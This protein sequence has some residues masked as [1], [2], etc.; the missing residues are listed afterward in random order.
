[1][2]TLLKYEIYRRWKWLILKY[3][4]FII[5]SIILINRAFST[6]FQYNVLGASFAKFALTSLVVLIVILVEGSNSLKEDLFEECG[7]LTFTIPKKGRTILASKQILLFLQLILWIIITWGFGS[8][9]FSK[10]PFPEIA[11][12][13]SQIN[14]SPMII[15]MLFAITLIFNF[16]LIFHFSLTLTK[17]LLVNKKHSGLLSFGIF[18]L[19]I[20]LIEKIYYGQFALQVKHIAIKIGVGSSINLMS[21]SPAD[22]I[23][24]FLNIILSV[25]FFT[26]TAYLLENKMNI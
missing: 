11:Q 3:S 9:F 1:M 5:I 13:K 2:I 20:Y 10:L 6:G 26:T 17:T 4:A 15:T 8:V 14:T 16:V 23:S 12:I 18:I 22:T 24:V 19:M 25:I 21:L 7:Y